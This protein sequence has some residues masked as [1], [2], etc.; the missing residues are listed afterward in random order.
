M[1]ANTAHSFTILFNFRS[2]C[3]IIQP[4]KN[5]PPPP[6]GTAMAPVQ[7][8]KHKCATPARSDKVTTACQQLMDKTD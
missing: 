4:P 8:D 7:S 1:A 5:V 2:L 6:A 3:L